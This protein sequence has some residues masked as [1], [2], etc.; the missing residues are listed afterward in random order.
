[1]SDLSFVGSLAR[2]EEGLAELEACG[3]TDLNPILVAGEA[4]TAC[5]DRTREVLAAH[6]RA[7]R[8]G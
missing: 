4:D 2:V 3:V 7:G 8:G 6:A 1:V 5:A